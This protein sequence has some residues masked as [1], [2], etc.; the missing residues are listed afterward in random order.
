MAPDVVE[1]R[2]RRPIL[3]EGPTVRLAPGRTPEFRDDPVGDEF[4]GLSELFEGHSPPRVHRADDVGV[5]GFHLAFYF[6]SD[7]LGRADQDLSRDFP[8]H[9]PREGFSASVPVAA[10]DSLCPSGRQLLLGSMTKCVEA[11]EEKR[12]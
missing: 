5:A 1:R 12:R 6:A 4:H 9:L 10:D 2:L 7:G 3:D 8:F 11:G